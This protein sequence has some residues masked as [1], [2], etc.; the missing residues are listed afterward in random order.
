M[1]FRLQHQTGFQLLRRSCLPNSQGE[2]TLIARF[3]G[4]TWGPSGAD[5]TQMGPILA[6]WSLLSGYPLR[7]Q[8]IIWLWEKCRLT[9]LL[10]CWRRIQLPYKSIVTF[11]SNANSHSAAKVRPVC[12]S[13]AGI[14][15]T[16]LAGRSQDRRWSVLKL[17][18]WLACPVGG[19]P[20]V[21]LVG[22]LRGFDPPFSRHW[23][24]I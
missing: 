15:P 8:N 17:G 12:W 14:W 16:V 1:H 9:H 7:R 13:P 19:T 23:E 11:V 18:P 3:M 6:P 10:R 24:K 4:P 2:A 22:R 21:K 20:S 5:R